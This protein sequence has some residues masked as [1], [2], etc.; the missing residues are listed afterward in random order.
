MGRIVL[1]GV[2][3][4]FLALSVMSYLSYER[5]QD[6]QALRNTEQG[7]LLVEIEGANTPITS[8]LAE[9]W[10]RF[11]P[12]PSAEQLSELRIIAQKVRNDPASAEQFTTEYKQKEIDGSPLA[13]ADTLFGKFGDFKAKPGL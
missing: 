6:R 1:A 9:E 12:A 13:N 7:Q 8:K 11:Y 2:F 10:Q 5:A 4:L 3:V